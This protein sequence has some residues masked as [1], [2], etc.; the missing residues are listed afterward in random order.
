MK[1][2]VSIFHKILVAMLLVALVPLSAIWYVDYRTAN[3]YTTTAIQQQLAELSDRTVTQ[4]NDWVGMNLKAL[5]Q[6]GALAD[7]VSMDPKRQN[8]ILRAMLNEYRWSYLVFTIGPNGMNIGRS[9]DKAPIDYSDRIYY[10]QIMAGNPMGSQVVI[11]KTTNKPALILSAPIYATDPAGARQTAGVVAMGMSIAE[12]SERITNLRIGKTGFAFLL[13][14]NGKVVAHQKEEY[15][16]TS[17]DFSQHPAF[18]GRPQSGRRELVYEDG[19]RKVIAYAQTTAQGWTMVTQ[20]DYDE[21]YAPVRNAA[22]RGVAI[23]VATIV[24][25][26]FVAYLVSRMLSNPIR[27]LTRIADEISRGRLVTKIEEVQRG[28][29]IGRLAGAID[30]MGTSIRLAMERLRS[31]SGS[32]S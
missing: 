27:N 11:S 15:A 32:G 9:D 1:V 22:L 6:N 13:D 8:P 25:V 3:S 31:G 29:E 26:T 5:N 21:A 20:Q 14:E 28:D 4:V 23:L 7:M 24:L 16:D 30:R 12:L 17:A 18:V 10:K 19:G 2:T